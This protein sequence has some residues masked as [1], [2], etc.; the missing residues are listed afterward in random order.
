[1]RTLSVGEGQIGGGRALDTS[2]ASSLHDQP[3]DKTN[4][5]DNIVSKVISE[6]LRTGSESLAIHF[7][8]LKNHVF[9]YT[10]NTESGQNPK[11]DK[12]MRTLAHH[13]LL[14]EGGKGKDSLLDEALE[15]LVLRVLV[16]EKE[17]IHEFYKS[18]ISS[19]KIVP[20]HK[21]QLIGEGSDSRIYAHGSNKDWIVRKE[22]VG[23]TVSQNEFRIGKQLNH[24][25]LV[26]FHEIYVKKYQGTNKEKR[27]IVGDRMYGTVIRGNYDKLSVSKEETKGLFMQLKNCA[28]YLFDHN[29]V[30]SDL[31]GGNIAYSKEGLKLFDYG[32][33]SENKDSTQKT[34]GLLVGAVETIDSVLAISRITKENLESIKSPPNYTS[35]S[36]S[37]SF[38]DQTLID[39]LNS[40]SNEEKKKFMC[41]YFDAAIEQLE[42]ADHSD[43]NILSQK[44]DEQEIGKL[45]KFIAHD[46]PGGPDWKSFTKYLFEICMSPS[47]RHI[48]LSVL[49]ES[50]DG[51]KNGKPVLIA[52]THWLDEQG[53]LESYYQFLTTNNRENVVAVMKEIEKGTQK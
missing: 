25:M 2:K 17:G 52:L 35:I 41:D 10:K 19:K 26:K 48:S 36:I 7:D 8:E 53:Q 30:W 46:R 50:M 21:D 13:L 6:D 14:H 51:H 24:P 43:R 4:Y 5:I 3:I 1:M 9:E 12:E 33:W 31:H 16:N 44:Q 42:N 29:I 22:N 38:N 47:D 32:Y 23:S 34:I 28:E 49:D 39:K 37:T 15:K 27:S 45:K 20:I 18:E 11:L 40:M